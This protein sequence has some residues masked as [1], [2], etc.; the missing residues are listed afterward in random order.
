M[1][2][3]YSN[4]PKPKADTVAQLNALKSWSQNPAAYYKKEQAKA[5]EKKLK[6]FVRSE[7]PVPRAVKVA[8]KPKP[9][10]QY[11]NGN[12]IDL[13]PLIHDPWWLIKPEKPEDEDTSIPIEKKINKRIA[14]QKRS[15]G[16][17]YLLGETI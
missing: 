11:L 15:E 3:K 17:A 2:Y 12:V 16:L 7:D 1:N 10:P 9:K 5:Y 14:K 4:G 13:K 6:A 8:K